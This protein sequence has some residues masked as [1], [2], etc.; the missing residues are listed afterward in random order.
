VA[1]AAKSGRRSAA[2][3][4]IFAAIRYRRAFAAESGKARLRGGNRLFGIGSIAAAREA[5]RISRR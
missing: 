3:M 1:V 5:G 4:M 2:T